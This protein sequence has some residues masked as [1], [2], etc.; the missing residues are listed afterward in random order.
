MRFRIEQRFEASPD[1]VARA[2]AD[3]QLYASFTDLPRAGRPQVL[4]HQLDGAIVELAIRWSFT[5]AL[6]SAAR[7]VIDP[8]RL[9]WVERSRHDLAAREVGFEM[10]PDHYADRF[11]CRGAV[12][13]SPGGDG[14]RRAVEGELTVRAPLVARSV[15]RA[16]VSG[17]DEQLQAE[18]GAV[19]RF[20]G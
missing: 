4:S 13:C 6:S 19:T 17:L 8:D 20:L 1:D 14:T 16:I 12:R 15:E 2:Y 7:A 3:P 10:L 11:S 9:T 5:A 18:I